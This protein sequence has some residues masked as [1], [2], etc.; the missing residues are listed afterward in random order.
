MKMATAADTMVTNMAVTWAGTDER[1]AMSCGSSV[2]E[3][4]AS[5]RSTKRL[6][7]RRMRVRTYA[8]MARGTTIQRAKVT[9]ARAILS[10]SSKNCG[11]KAMSA[12]NRET[13][14]RSSAASTLVGRRTA[15]GFNRPP[16]R[17][18]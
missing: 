2:A 5:E 13:P 17:T 4:R 1:R 11:A 14:S 6:P 12:P 8:S 3:P 10:S 9:V 7:L 15:A 16:R 18:P